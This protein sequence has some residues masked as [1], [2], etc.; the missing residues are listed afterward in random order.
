MPGLKEE[1]WLL[2]VVVIRSPRENCE[3]ISIV[4]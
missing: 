2:A 1:A 3:Q 4:L